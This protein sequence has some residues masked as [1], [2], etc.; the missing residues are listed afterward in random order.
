MFKHTMSNKDMKSIVWRFISGSDDWLCSV[1]SVAY[2]G[3][4]MPIAEHFSGTAMLFVFLHTTLLSVF[5]SR[6]NFLFFSFSMIDSRSHVMQA[7]IGESSSDKTQYI[8]G[9]FYDLP[10]SDLHLKLQ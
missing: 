3:S 4:R 10:D 6:V 7:T 1:L 9:E 8:P 5:V 2:A